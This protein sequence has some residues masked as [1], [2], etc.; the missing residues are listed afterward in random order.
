LLC[1]LII[2]SYL[3]TV[4]NAFTFTNVFQDNPPQKSIVALPPNVYYSEIPAP[5]LNSSLLRNDSIQPYFAI[6][7]SSYNS[8]TKSYPVIYF[9]HGYGTTLHKDSGFYKLFPTDEYLGEAIIVLGHG[10]H[11]LLQGVDYVNSPVSGNWE[12]F[13]VYDLINY[14]DTNFRTI[15][16]RN[17][18]GIA[19]YSMG[20]F[21]ALNIAMK[22]PDVFGTTYAICPG[23]FDSGGMLE[24]SYC[25][26]DTVNNFL[27]V[28]DM[29]D[30]LPNDTI[31]HS[32]YITW[33]KNNWFVDIYNRFTP[34]PYGSAFSPNTNKRAPYIDFHYY[35]HENGSIIKNETNWLNWER[36]YGDL[37]SKISAYKTNI[38]SLNGI[39]IDY[40]DND[41]YEWVP[42]GVEY[43]SALLEAE[44]VDHFT[45]E[46]SYAH[47]LST[48][49]TNA[50]LKD[51]MIPFF[52]TIFEKAN[53]TTTTTTETDT[54]TS[55][56]SS[57]SITSTFINRFPEFYLIILSLPIL[58]LR[59][60]N[61]ET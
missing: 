16:D 55:I 29:L 3:I 59:K 61:K 42:D 46:N 39:G 47:S 38:L 37:E 30:S 35:K 7:P 54:L 28:Q 44:G 17:F 56:S 9:L 11:S 22:H 40:D 5:S 23:L 10:S 53:K 20:G 51:H 2:G 19:G 33:L 52:S 32:E 15:P 13:I 50:R 43:F 14:T 26:I 21:G 36:G 24:S 49:G 27:G 18:R 6:L 48:S 60:K 4:T 25:D 45:V 8:S 12:D 41:I 34:F 1:F 57:T 58:W 31:A